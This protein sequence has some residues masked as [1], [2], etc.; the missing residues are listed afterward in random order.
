MKP[1]PCIAGQ[2]PTVGLET[3][4]KKGRFSSVG[5]VFFP[6]P[7]NDIRQDKKC[8]LLACF[9]VMAKTVDRILNLR[10]LTE[11]SL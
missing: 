9:A 2:T 7:K 11:E 1:L 6:P 4:V 8:I 3:S 5:T 10:N